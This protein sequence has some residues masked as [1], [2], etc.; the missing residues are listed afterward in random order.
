MYFQLLGIKTKPITS[1]SLRLALRRAGI[2]KDKMT[3]HGFRSMASTRL[4]ELG[5]KADLIEIQLSHLPANK[6]RAAYNHAEYLDERRVMMQQWS[7]YLNQ[8]QN[9]ENS[10]DFDL[11]A[12]S[13]L[14]IRQILLKRV[15]G[16]F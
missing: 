7:D 9:K 2:G 16:S 10:F 12:K 1:D 11:P 3:P 4:N 6:V 14:G 15:I 5:Y 8:L 13:F